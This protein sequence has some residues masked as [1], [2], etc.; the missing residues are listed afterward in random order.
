[1]ISRILNKVGEEKGEGSAL[2][3][4]VGLFQEKGLKSS[5]FSGKEWRGF[6]PE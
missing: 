2:R 6:Y 5:V 1:V 4:E 3:G